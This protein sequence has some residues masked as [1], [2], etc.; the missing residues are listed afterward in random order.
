MSRALLE[1]LAKASTIKHTSVLSESKFF[2]D[3]REIVTDLPILNLAFSGSLKGGFESGLTTVAGPSKHFKSNLA[4]Y[5]VS[6]YLRDP[7]A[8]CLYFDSEF[9]APPPYLSQ[10]GIDLDRVLHI[11]IRHI[12]EL[13]FEMARQLDQIQRGDKVI[14][15]IDSIGN[16]ASKKEV[17]DA[18]NE[19]SAADM[20]R[21]KQLKSLWRMVT[22]EFT[23]KDIPCIN[24]N[25]TYE[26]QEMYSKSVV[27]GGTGGMYSSSTV[28]II[29]RS[30]EKDDEGLAGYKFTI[31]IEKSRKV[32]EKS[33]F[34]FTVT[35][36]RGINKWSG[37][38]DIALELGFVTKP[39]NGWYTRPL[40][41]GDR[42]WRIKDTDCEEF[43]GPLLEDEHFEDA[44][45]QRFQLG[46]YDNSEDEVEMEDE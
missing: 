21:A 6:A 17:E 42:N 34:A 36:K 37:L 19:K 9:G 29:G 46:A 44:L 12:E 11:P 45:N 27:S 10:F 41:E 5:C 1:K 14:I 4:L 23:I 31:N 25:H 3:K 24:I 18:L 13:K 43:W 8:I 16:L 30:Q 15:F 26:T 38:M 35:F 28:F 7:D 32:R 33:K 20:T 39:K 40:I 22:P 2:D